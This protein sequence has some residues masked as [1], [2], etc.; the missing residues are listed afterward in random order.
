MVLVSQFVRTWD[1]ATAPWLVGWLVG[2]YYGSGR[3]RGRVTA[4]GAKT[5]TDAP[6]QGV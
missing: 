5:M 2:W 3:L 4:A 6:L 1:G